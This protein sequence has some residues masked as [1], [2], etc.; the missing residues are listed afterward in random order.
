MNPSSLRGHS[1]TLAHATRRYP[2]RAIGPGAGGNAIDLPMSRQDIADYL[3]MS[4]D[5]VSR[6]LTSL[7]KCSTIRV[8]SRR[9]V[10]RPSAE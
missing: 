4:I 1:R 7:Q 8:L 10:V 3:G 2:E 6:A 9:I 5:T